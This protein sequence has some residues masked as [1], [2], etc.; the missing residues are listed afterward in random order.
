[1]EHTIAAPGD[2]QV[3]ELRDQPFLLQHPQRPDLG[4][5]DDDR[6]IGLPGA[7]VGHDAVVAGRGALEGT[8]IA[9]DS[10]GGND[11]DGV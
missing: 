11:T 5:V 10:H 6:I 3:A 9:V 7:D 4:D 8:C 2:G 1:M